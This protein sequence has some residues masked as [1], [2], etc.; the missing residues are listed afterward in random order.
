MG[1]SMGGLISQY[2]IDRYPNVFSKAGIFSPAYW[3]A[4]P[5]FDYAKAQ[6][7]PKDAKLYFYAGGREGDSMVPDM[8]R[9]VELDHARLSAKN[10]AVKVDPD[11][12]HNEAAWRAQFAQAVLWLF[13]PNN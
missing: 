6:P 2:A 8:Q 1:S 7:L 5:V 10:I 12:Q 3:L 11:A 4:P 9:M 13:G